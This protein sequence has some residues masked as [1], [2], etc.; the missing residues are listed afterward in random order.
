MYY[1]IEGFRGNSKAFAL[2][3]E[4]K[5]NMHKKT[6]SIL[7]GI[8][9]TVLFIVTGCTSQPKVIES[10]PITET[11][12]ILGTVVSL[13]IYDGI[14]DSEK[15]EV[16][17]EVFNTLKEIE[18]KM[19]INDASGNDSEAMAINNMAGKD[20]VTVSKDT[21]NVI[22]QGKY[23][24][25]ISNGGFDVSIGALVKLWNIGE[26][27][28]TVPSQQDIETKKALVDFNKVQI[29]ESTSEVKLEQEG[30]ILDLGGI[31]K[32][33]G[34]DRITEI[35]KEHG[36]GHAIINLGGNIYA[37]GEKVDGSPWRIGIQNP[38]SSRGDYVGIVQVVDKTVVTS[39]IYERYFEEN[40]VRYHHIL[41]RETGYPVDNNLAGVSIIAEKSIDADALSTAVFVNGPEQG[42]A[43]I[44][45]LE[46]I[47][48][49]FITKDNKL[50]LSSGIKES[51]KL[52]DENYKI[53]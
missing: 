29:N 52:T 38:N 36:I 42:L 22:K 33:Y 26:E 9:I 20:F 45:S 44:E 48:A 1:N 21:L 12:F 41:D 11:E 27:G 15:K 10:E 13:T 30:M 24:S 16:F 5:I 53:Q 47:E 19:T 37:H 4:V 43:L 40:G 34:A 14:T 3:M 49:I 7:L 18:L 28:V 50:L 46:N 8:L 31:A 23:F 6:K 2:F 35:L 25:E 32:G 17:E 39:G 51:F